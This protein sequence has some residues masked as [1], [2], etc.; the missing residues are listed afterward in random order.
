M[1][2]LNFLEYFHKHVL[3]NIFRSSWFIRNE[4]GTVVPTRCRS[5][6]KPLQESNYRE[7]CCILMFKTRLRVC[8]TFPLMFMT[9]NNLTKTTATFVSHCHFLRPIIRP[10][11]NALQLI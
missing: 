11:R 7:Q 2:Q 8:T 10:Q 5:Y 1:G 3:D 4:K 6:L 9:E